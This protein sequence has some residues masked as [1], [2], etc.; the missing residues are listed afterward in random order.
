MQKTL[1]TWC[2]DVQNLHFFIDKTTFVCFLFNPVGCLEA[3]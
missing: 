3:G 2:R 1:T